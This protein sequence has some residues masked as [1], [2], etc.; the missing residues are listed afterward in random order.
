LSNHDVQHLKTSIV[1]SSKTIS[2][3]TYL[4]A[5]FLERAIG[6]IS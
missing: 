6:F 2:Q 1:S 5:T 3:I 4:F